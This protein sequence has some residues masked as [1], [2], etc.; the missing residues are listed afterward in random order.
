MS[1]NYIRYNEQGINQFRELLDNLT[2]E[3]KSLRMTTA[4]QCGGIVRYTNKG[5]GLLGVT[6]LQHSLNELDHQIANSLRLTDESIGFTLSITHMMECAEEKIKEFLNTFAPVKAIADFLS[7]GTISKAE[8]IG[9]ILENMNSKIAQLVQNF[10]DVIAI[11]LGNVITWQ[12]AV[13]GNPNMSDEIVLSDVKTYILQ[14]KTIKG[15]KDMNIWE[16]IKTYPNIKNKGVM[17][18]FNDEYWNPEVKMQCTLYAAARRAMIGKPLPGGAWG[19]GGSWAAS[20]MKAGLN[21]D[22]VPNAG[23]V[24]SVSSGYYGHVGVVE[25]VNTDGTILISEGNYD[26][27]GSYRLRTVKQSEWRSWKFIT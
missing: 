17:C 18:G 13:A 2:V 14:G 7:F 10:D 11:I 22:S 21:V 8:K 6:A 3:L 23:D 27:K 20:A 12:N 16:L 24:F 4:E 5:V 9:E 19:N 25:K 15:Y 1:T 26:N